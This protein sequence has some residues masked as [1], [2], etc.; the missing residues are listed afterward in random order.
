VSNE[1]I[2]FE[3]LANAAGY[4]KMNLGSVRSIADFENCVRANFFAQD[5]FLTLDPETKPIPNRRE[6]KSQSEEVAYGLF[7]PN[8]NINWLEIFSGSWTIIAV[9]A[10]EVWLD[11]FLESYSHPFV[12]SHSTL[13]NS[14]FSGLLPMIK[15]RPTSMLVALNESR[16]VTVLGRGDNY[17]KIVRG[18]AMRKSTV[19]QTTRTAFSI[20]Y[21]SSSALKVAEKFARSIANMLS[22]VSLV[23]S[24]PKLKVSPKRTT[25]PKGASDFCET[26]RPPKNSEHLTTRARAIAVTGVQKQHLKP[27]RSIFKHLH[28][29]PARPID[30]RTIRERYG[31]HPVLTEIAHHTGAEWLIDEENVS[32]LRFFTSPEIVDETQEMMDEREVMDATC[33]EIDNHAVLV[34]AQFRESGDRICVL[35]AGPKAGAVAILSHD[36]DDAILAESFKE[37]IA[38]L[39]ADAVSLLRK[40]G[41]ADVALGGKRLK[42]Y[43]V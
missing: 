4:F 12:P 26:Q 34:I 22:D 28:G 31:D 2:D 24:E 18:V 16:S 17:K 23:L 39:D 42:P 15:Y 29:F 32:H 8:S 11:K 25:D 7:K 38:M 19:N 21:Y 6:M 10:D 43:D 36:S 27:A 14:S 41:V 9:V 3:T 35:L 1:R 13:D 30:L 40:F 37:F 20:D 33:A 5:V